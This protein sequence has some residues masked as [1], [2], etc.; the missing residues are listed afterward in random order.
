MFRICWNTEEVA[1]RD[2]LKD[3]L[4]SR[5]GLQSNPVSRWKSRGA[6]PPNTVVVVMMMMMSVDSKG[7]QEPKVFRKKFKLPVQWNVCYALGRK[8]LPPSGTQASRPA[9]LRLWYQKVKV[10]PVGL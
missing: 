6:T 3:L 9:D 8:V 1:S 7:H 5:H 2:A 10:F 4:Y